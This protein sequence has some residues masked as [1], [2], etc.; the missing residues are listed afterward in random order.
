MSIF[1]VG[2]KTLLREGFSEPELY[3][4]LVYKFKKLTGRND[5]SVQFRKFIT[6]YRRRGYNFHVMRNSALVINPIMFDN[7]AAFFYCT[8]VGRDQLTPAMSM[9]IH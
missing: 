1:H 4:D 3:S 2:L 8:R 5:F 9:M 7:Y 6:R